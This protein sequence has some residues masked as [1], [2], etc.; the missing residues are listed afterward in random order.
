MGNWSVR[1]EGLSKKFGKTVRQNL[2][3]GLLDSGR[4]LIGMG[5]DSSHLRP[6]EFWA[7]DDVNFELKPGDGLGIMGVNG[8]GKTTLLRI[9]NGVFSPDRGRAAFRG[10]IGALIAAGAGFSPLLTGRENVYVNGTILGMRPKEISRQFDEIVQFSGLEEFIDMPVRNY[11]SGM[12]V[13]LGFAVAVLGNPDVLLVDEVLAVGDFS[14]QKR[15]FERILELLKNG[16][17]VIFVSHSIGAVWSVCNQGLFLNKGKSSGMQT[18]EETCRAYEL[19]SYRDLLSSDGSAAPPTMEDGPDGGV[20]LTGGEDRPVRVTRFRMCDVETGSTKWEFDFREPLMLKM[21]VVVRESIPDALFRYSFNAV[22]YKFIA[23]TDSAYSDG[24]GITAVEPGRYVVTTI[25]RDQSF[26]PGTYSVNL[27]VCRKGVGIH[28]FTQQNAGR[29]I[30]KPIRDR[31]LYD[32]DGP[33]V[34]HFDAAYQLEKQ[35]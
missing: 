35:A 17:T 14:F 5:K 20:V 12:A 18:V 34:V 19:E 27:A 11:S 24:I 23:A 16:T 29:F 6:G 25:L 30:I 31:F 26:H 13:R 33:S 22:H 2:K 4:R 7:L 10:S 21:E 9:L 32:S 3:Y 1:V 28:L 15:C 8:S